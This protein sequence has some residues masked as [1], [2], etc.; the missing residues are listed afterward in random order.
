MAATPD[1]DEV[2]RPTTGKANFQ[3]VT[4]LLISGG[5]T[6]LREVFDLIY[7]PSV[8]PTILQN[9]ST[10]TTLKTAGLTKPQRD[11][12]Y[13]SPGVYGKSAE[14]DI[15]LLFK[16]LRTICNLV[17]PATGWDRFPNVLVPSCVLYLCSISI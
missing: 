3:R 11:C 10:K 13:P 8:L 5:T 4:R 9:P 14:F 6:L 17:P 1:P 15:T 2:L 16:L 12:L 7:P